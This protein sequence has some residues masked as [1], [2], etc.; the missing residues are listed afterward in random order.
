MITGSLNNKVDAI[1]QDFYNE[2]KAQ[3]TDV[4][5][6]LTMLMFIKMLDDKQNDL[7]SRALAIGITP[8]QA[9]LAFKMEIIKTTR[10]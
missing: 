8:N 3:N 9:D 4:V 7:E 10:S 5:N 2:N 1:R 6:Q